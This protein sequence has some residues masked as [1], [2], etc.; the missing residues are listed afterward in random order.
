MGLKRT[1]PAIDDMHIDTLPLNSHYLLHTKGHSR[2]A[3][4]YPV[5]LTLRLG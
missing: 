1:L 3:G 2:V 4:A 5:I